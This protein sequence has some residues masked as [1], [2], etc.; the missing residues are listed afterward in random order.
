M[1]FSVVCW[2][3]LISRLKFSCVTKTVKHKDDY[4]KN[5]SFF[6]NAEHIGIQ[7][8]ATFGK[9]VDKKKV[10]VPVF[11]NYFINSHLIT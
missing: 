3:S 1:P 6:S 4:P 7:I 2:K 5:L 8:A 10:W 11:V 9:V